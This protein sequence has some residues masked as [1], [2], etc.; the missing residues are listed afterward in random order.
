VAPPGLGDETNELVGGYTLISPNETIR[1]QLQERGY[2]PQHA[3]DL[4]RLLDSTRPEQPPGIA[5]VIDFVSWARQAKDSTSRIARSVSLLLRH[6][7]STGGLAAYLVRMNA[8]R[9]GW[10]QPLKG[11]TPKVTHHCLCGYSL[12]L[13]TP[14][15]QMRAYTS[16]VRVHSVFC[17]HMDVTQAMEYNEREKYST[18]LLTAWI[19]KMAVCIP[20]GEG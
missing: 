4:I 1:N 5:V 14:H 9:P 16:G 13:D 6:T 11:W 2:A 3:Y 8:P 12:S 20:R 10:Q 7:M 15:V 17:R 19:A 18:M